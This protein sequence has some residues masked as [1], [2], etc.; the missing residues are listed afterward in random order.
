M[1][2][3]LN[4][5]R[6]YRLPDKC[7]YS[8]YLATGYAISTKQYTLFKYIENEIALRVSLSVFPK[9]HSRLRSRPAELLIDKMSIDFISNMRF[10]A[11]DLHVIGEN[12]DFHLGIKFGKQPY[13]H[14]LA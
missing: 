10:T 8:Q 5:T 11:V 2:F 9:L 13:E 6:S 7:R 1:T 12:H 4:L 14:E 3:N